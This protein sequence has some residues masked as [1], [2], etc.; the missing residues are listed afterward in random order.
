MSP[1]AHIHTLD[2][3]ANSSEDGAPVALSNVFKA[4][5]DSLRT[6]IIRLLKDD[7]LSVSE[8]CEVFRIR[9]SALSHHLK[10]LVAAD[11]VVRRKEGTA[12]F[13]RRQLP[14]GDLRTLLEQIF[15]SI[16][17]EQLS[18]DLEAG[19]VRVQRQREQNSI[20]FFRDNSA[21]FHQQRELIASWQDYSDATLHMIGRCGDLSDALV[22]EIGPG[23]GSLL[24]ALAKIA[25]RVVA[26]DN[27][28]L[29]LEAARATAS[30]LNNV[31]FL[32]GTSAD[33]RSYLQQA[34]NA[35]QSGHLPNTCSL[36]VANM[37]L[38]HTPDP[39]NVLTETASCLRDGGW[40]VVSE[41]CAHDQV[42]AREHCGDLWLGFEP[43]QLTQWAGDAGLVN[44]AEL[45]I[46]QRNGFQIQVRLF[47][48]S[49]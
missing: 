45:F 30:H 39:R 49:I 14:N 43:G 34:S 33:I 23:D 5:G 47:Q 42:W 32:L 4:L 11:L 48:R 20:E 29:M 36:A 21:R 44:R 7:S 25:G 16:D 6:Q 17:A 18:A 35:T 10:I 19:L 27:S 22:V 38:H 13:Y 3:N 41:L 26:V 1:T 37:V 46:A 40:L 31:D 12:V 28:P 9:Q 8:L 24:P 2:S 15:L